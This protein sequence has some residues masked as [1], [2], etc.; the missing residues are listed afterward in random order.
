VG[1]LFIALPGE[2]FDGHDYAEDALQKGAVALLLE[3]LHSAESCKSAAVAIVENTRRALGQLAARYRNDF[4]LPVVAVGGSNGKTTTKELIGS[5]LR[6]RFRTLQSKASY[7]NDIGVPL[8][9]LRLALSHQAAVFEV[10]TNHPG[11]LAPLVA[12]VQPLFSVI[13]N[14]GREHLEF[15]GDLPGVVQEEGWLAELLPAEGKLFIDGDGEWTERII[16]RTSARVIRVGMEIGNNWRASSVK[17]NEGGSTFYVDSPIEGS[18]GSYRVNLLGRHQAKNALFALAVGAELGL[19]REELQT[20]LTDCRPPKMRLEFWETGG[21]GV[22][23]D[24]YNA[25]ADSM[26]GI[27]AGERVDDVER[28]LV[29]EVV[30]AAGDNELTNPG[31]S[32]PRPVRRIELSFLQPKSNS[33]FAFGK[34]ALGREPGSDGSQLLNE[35]AKVMRA[36]KPSVSSERVDTLSFT[37]A[38]LGR[39]LTRGRG[40]DSLAGSFTS[41]PRGD[42]IAVKVF[43]ADGEGE[44]FLNLNPKTGDG[45]FSVKDPDYG[46]VVLRELSKVL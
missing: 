35:L 16:Q 28:R 5:V 43:V 42:W 36:Q 8:T 4:K 44:F 31:D 18:N 29:R 21:V 46:D 9:L 37:T 13:T 33:P 34:G 3:K 10:G 22:L 2:R 17:V 15:F 38:V 25:N 40:K 45:E 11:E 26:L 20:G 32:G 23:D 19:G 6:Q 39:N 30:D 24:C 7:N 41:K 12:M 27:P 1:D 14:I